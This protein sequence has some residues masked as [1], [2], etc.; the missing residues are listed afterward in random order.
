[1]FAKQLGKTIEVY[2]DDMLVKS[3]EASQ[4]M[5]HFE[6]MFDVL[7]QYRMKLNSQKCAFSI[8]SGKFLIFIV[9]HRGIEANLKKIKV[10]VEMR[11]PTKKKEVQKLTK[12]V[13]ALNRFVS[14][15][16]DQCVPLFNTL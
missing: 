10:L 13:A 1:M 4:H 2:V 3:K 16:I 11:S 8:A 6:E 14:K 12:C 9:S 7:R 5:S 15:A